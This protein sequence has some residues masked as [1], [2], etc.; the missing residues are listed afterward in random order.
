MFRHPQRLAAPVAILAALTL[1]AVPATAVAAP[2][3]TPSSSPEQQLG[4][5]LRDPFP[6]IEL[7]DRIK[8]PDAFQPEGITTA[9]PL[10]WFGSRAD[11]DIYRADLLTGEGEVISQGPGTPSVGLTVDAK[12]RL[13]VSGGTGGD[14]RV[15]DGRTGEVLATYDF[16]GGFVNDVVVTKH[17]AYFT[18]SERSVVH[19][20]HLG[21][22]GTPTDTSDE[23]ALHGDWEQVDGFN[24]NGITT[25]P[26]GR[27]LLVVNSTTGDLFRVDPA[28]GHAY[29]VDLGD[30]QLA[31]GDGM[32]RTGRTLYVAQ[33]TRNQVATVR[34]DRAASEGRV[35]QTRTSD[36]FDTPTTIA[37]FAG[38]LYLPNARFTTTPQEDTGYW[39]TRLPLH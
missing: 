10:A 5:A 37:G 38:A 36:D 12:G 20:L 35:L 32:L 16:G 25:S 27:S 15:V 11:G 31:N 30:D 33:N 13:F 29:L 21:P 22:G 2:G 19:R 39:V 18:D 34:L 17:Y 8:L 9:G 26:D 3:A 7:P 1:A 23:L 14:A 6:Q 28:N 4:Q 24:A